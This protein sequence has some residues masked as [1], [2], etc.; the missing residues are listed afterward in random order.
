MGSAA[1]ISTGKS[2]GS[3]NPLRTCVVTRTQ[4]APERLIRFVIASDTTVVPDLD[5]RLPGRG[6]WV[7]ATR[8]AVE[9]AV[10][11]NAFARALR[12][13][14]RA[15]P[16]LPELIERLLAK[17]ALEALSLARKAGLVV[18]GFAK[19]E[20][21][22]LR[23]K[24]AA[25]VHARDAARDGVRKLDGK[26]LAVSRQLNRPTEIVTAFSVAELSLAIGQPNVVHAALEEGGASAHFLSAA[27]RLV[28]YG[29]ELEEAVDDAS[30]LL[31][32]N[33][34]RKTGKV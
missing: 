9:R 28:R 25:L 4:R 3:A 11:T 7:S 19:I 13:P 30:V 33:T 1:E 2:R 26:Y 20:A 15:A 21:A 31:A 18:T 16:E 24:V 8:G 22:I 6:L 27:K 5:R 12:G 23:G 17:R 32:G 34:V 10:K 29:S 14:A